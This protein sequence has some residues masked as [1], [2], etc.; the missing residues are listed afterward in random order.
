MWEMRLCRV[1]ATAGDRQIMAAQKD[2]QRENPCNGGGY[3]LG[4][5]K[6]ERVERQG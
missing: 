3:A 2:T 4:A 1:K 5:K 6:S